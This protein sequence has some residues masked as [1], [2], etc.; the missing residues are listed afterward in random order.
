MS[1]SLISSENGVSLESGVV[2]VSS[3]QS[4]SAV[5]Y[6]SGSAP[7]QPP[8]SDVPDAAPANPDL[9]LWFIDENVPGTGPKPDYLSSKFGSQAA[10]AKAYKDAERKL[11]SFSGAPEEYSV[12]SFEQ[13]EDWSFDSSDPMFQDFQSYAK[14][15]NMS[16]DI[17]DGIVNRYIEGKISSQTTPEHEIEK[18]G[19]DGQEKINTVTSWINNN[20][21]S[22]EAESLKSMATSAEKVMM[23]DKLRK[24]TRESG[25]P[26]AKEASQY[27]EKLN[28]QYLEQLVQ[29]PRYMT[30]PVF[31]AETTKKFEAHYGTN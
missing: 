10:Q 27:Q 16:Q 29:D 21:S 9:E 13:R 12:E 28:A 24:L 22:E 18:L 11:G 2:D 15:Q 1:E 3:A 23:L 31:R 25:L 14:E 7:I 17:F 19:P 5:G 26:S 8:S 30:D 6:E 4:E 20:F